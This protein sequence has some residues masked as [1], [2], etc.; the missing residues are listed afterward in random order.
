MDNFFREKFN[1]EFQQSNYDD[2]IKDINNSTGNR[3]DFKVNETPLFLDKNFTNE[4]ILAGEEILKVI[5]TKEFLEKSKSAIPQNLI[6]PNENDHPI[7]LQIDFGVAKDESGKIIPQLI[8]LQGFP[9]LYAYQ[10]FLEQKIREHFNISSELTA[11]YNG[12][13]FGLYQKFFK[14][15]LLKNSDPE[16]VI[17]LEI[18]PEK[19]KTRIDF[20]LTEKYTGIKTVCLTEV[21]KRGNKLFYKKNGIEIPIDRI[22]NRVI[23]DEMLRKNLQFDFSF[24]DDL[25]VTWIGHPNWFYKI[26]KFSLPLIKN[27]YSPPCFYLNDL[28]K[29]PEDLE[30]YV[31]KPLFSFAG[32]GVVIDL[33]KDI[34]NNI[35]DKSNYI[36]QKKVNYEPIIKTPDGFAKAEI[37]MMYI[38]NDKPM[39]VNNLLRTSKGKMMGVDFNKNQTWI[40]SSTIFHPV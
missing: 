4:L 7:F 24:K 28:E 6:V 21:I 15:T 10:A 13:D 14:H 40:G 8:E 2:F 1:N 35:E 19:Q 38:W 16:N 3:L 23:F 17:L 29:L 27:K 39:L 32:S 37:R 34:L 25:D 26:S 11:Y 18:E 5:Q 30:N 9:S 33:T 22:Y 36:L 20:F 12:F 31:L